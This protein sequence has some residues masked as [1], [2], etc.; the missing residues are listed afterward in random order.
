M[1]TLEK[2]QS[3]ADADVKTLDFRNVPLRIRKLG[4]SDGAAVHKLLPDDGDAFDHQ[5]L[6]NL[7]TFTVSKSLIGDDGKPDADSDDSRDALAKLPLPYLRELYEECLRFSGLAAD[8]AK[9]NES[10][11]SLTDSPTGSASP[12]EKSTPTT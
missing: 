8:D 6:I 4:A 9:K 2:L 5:Q 3:A 11:P 10:G 1:N 7:Y 12:S